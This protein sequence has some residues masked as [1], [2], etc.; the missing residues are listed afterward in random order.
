[1]LPLSDP[2]WQTYR[3]GHRVVYDASP[4]LRQLL[5]V[6]AAQ[7]LWD[8]LWE[9][10]HHQG[11]V[12]AA[13]YAAVPYLLA[14]S[15]QSKT[16]D[17]NA[18]ALISTIE[19]A[20][21]DNPAPPPELHNAY[22]QAVKQLPAIVCNHPQQEWDDTLTRSIV[23]CIALARSQRILASVYLEMTLEVAQVWLEETLGTDSKDNC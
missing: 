11:D 17:W 4:L 18:F 19:L 8:E 1:M 15:A 20:R 13:S 22:F 6:G 3:S 21:P 7:H 12:D 9:E 2:R 14:F 16:L 23:S 10:L 5:E